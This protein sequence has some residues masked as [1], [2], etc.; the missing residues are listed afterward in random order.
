MAAGLHDNAGWRG[1]KRH[2]ER[3]LPL[4]ADG[5]AAGAVLP[6]VYAVAAV[7]PSAAGLREPGAG[8]D[9]EPGDGIA[10]H[11]GHRLSCGSA[12]LSP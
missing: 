4:V 12:C 8:V 6:E 9:E 2:D 11:S 3:A 5:G 1:Q 7:H 10:R